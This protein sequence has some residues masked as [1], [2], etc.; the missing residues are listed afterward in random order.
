[1]KSKLTLFLILS[2]LFLLGGTAAAAE[3]DRRKVPPAAA[4]LVAD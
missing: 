3:Y 4:D 1:M 2:V